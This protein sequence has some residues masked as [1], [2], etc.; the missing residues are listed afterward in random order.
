MDSINRIRMDSNMADF[1][2]LYTQ[3]LM[4]KSPIYCP[5]HCLEF[6][7]CNTT[8]GPS[9]DSYNYLNLVLKTWSGAQ[10][11]WTF[12]G[13]RLECN[14]DEYAMLKKIMSL[15]TRKTMTPARIPLAFEL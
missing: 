5:Q 13:R 10:D 2:K 9:C 6:S 4:V 11:R 8:V 15:V 12:C 14:F 1:Q 3:F 7:Y